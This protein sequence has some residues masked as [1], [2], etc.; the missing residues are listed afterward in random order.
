L[1][2]ALGDRADVVLTG[3][4]ILPAKLEAL[5]FRFDFPSVDRALA[6][7]YPPG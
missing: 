3:R 5:G 6:D 7:L 4:R 1:K 2:L